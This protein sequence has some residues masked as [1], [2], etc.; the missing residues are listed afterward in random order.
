MRKANE[1]NDFIDEDYSEDEDIEIENDNQQHVQVIPPPTSRSIII[2][3]ITPTVVTVTT[4]LSAINNQRIEAMES[5]TSKISSSAS[6]LVPMFI[7][8]LLSFT[9][10]YRCS[11]VNHFLF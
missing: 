7:S 9:S 10:L 4:T 6:H 5:K 1:L 8:L 11:Y 2:N 3:S